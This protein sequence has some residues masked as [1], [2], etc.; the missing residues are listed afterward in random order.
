[1]DLFMIFLRHNMRTLDSQLREPWF[2]SSCYRIKAFAILFPHITT[3][4]S[5]VNE[6]PGRDRGGNVSE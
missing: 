2:K 6:Y 3:V 1:M 4:H 5:A